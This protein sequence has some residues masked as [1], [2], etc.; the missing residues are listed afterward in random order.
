MT[1]TTAPAPLATAQRVRDLRTLWRVL[2]AIALPIGPLLVTITRW[3]M[4][5]WT[6]DDGPTMVSKSLAHLDRL[7]TM[8]WL[9]LFMVPAL[10]IS[11]L[12]IGYVARRGAPVLATIGAAL[13]F[14]AYVNW[15]ATG[16]TDFLMLTAG[17][18]GVDPATINKVLDATAN[19]HPVAAISGFG[20][21]IG[22]ILGTVLL[23]IALLRAK[24]IPTLAGIAMI[25]SQ[26]VHLVAAVIVPSRV[27][28]VVA[29]WGLTT[30]AFAVVAVVILRTHNDDWDLPPAV[31]PAPRA[32]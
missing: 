30:V 31:K 3:I 26:P 25:V 11:L 14:L 32:A 28:D 21:V 22:H 23:G 6:T 20:W 1:A 9:S 16:N 8:A 5:Y 19:H 7:N 12:A 18:A 10:V 17:Q 2:I 29:G 15:S 24:K 4:P 13:S 27:L